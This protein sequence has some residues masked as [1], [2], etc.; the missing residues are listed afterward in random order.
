MRSLFFVLL[1]GCGGG[2]APEA[3]APAPE[4]PAPAPEPKAAPAPE[5]PAPA[6]TGEAKP[7][8][9]TA[10]EAV[11]TDNCVAC[12][13][14]DG[15]GMGGMLAADFTK[16]KER[17]AKSDEELMKSIRDGVVGK[18]GTMPPWGELLSEQERADALAYIRK[19]FGSD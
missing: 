18:K 3:P 7:G 17:L 8:D 11:Y 13:Q 10:G 9:A 12:H 1:V 5:A 2:T 6:P 15:T 16:E 4:A 19:T 14:A